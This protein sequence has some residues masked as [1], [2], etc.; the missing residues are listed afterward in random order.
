MLEPFSR[1][2]VTT[3]PEQVSFLTGISKW[4]EYL[5]G[6]L[7]TVVNSESYTGLFSKL[8]LLQHSY[9]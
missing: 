8:P 2:G 3:R 7:K 5:D 4:K 9:V 6:N 1:L